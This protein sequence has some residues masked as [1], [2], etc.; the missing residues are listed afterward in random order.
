VLHQVYYAQREYRKEHKRWAKSLDE[1]GIGKFDNK[2]LSESLRLE[3]TSTGFEVSGKLRDPDG[4]GQRWHIRQDGR[5][6]AED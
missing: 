2:L 1:L 3:T 5:V 4:K 6:W